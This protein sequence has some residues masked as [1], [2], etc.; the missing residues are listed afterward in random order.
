M[1]KTRPRVLLLSLLSAPS[2]DPS[3]PPHCAPSNTSNQLPACA[4]GVDHVPATLQ[5]QRKATKSRGANSNFWGRQ[6]NLSRREVGAE[7]AGE[8]RAHLCFFRVLFAPLKPAILLSQS[9]SLG[10]WRQAASTDGSRKRN[11]GVPKE[12]QEERPGEEELLSLEVARAFLEMM[13]LCGQNPDTPLSPSSAATPTLS[14]PPAD[15]GGRSAC[16]KIKEKLKLDLEFTRHQK[17]L[18]RREASEQRG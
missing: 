8:P 12:E 9:T 11:R 7:S 5:H 1:K 13:P 17:H 2:L 6:S 14:P 10:R 15:S 18:A 4:N 16:A 3:T